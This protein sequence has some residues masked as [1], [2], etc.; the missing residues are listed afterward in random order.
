LNA[1]QYLNAYKAC[2]KDN[3]RKGKKGKEDIKKIE[4]LENY[5]DKKIKLLYLFEHPTRF[6]RLW[7]RTSRHPRLGVL[8]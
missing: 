6:M 2:L 4:A 8:L 7:S 1:E 5:L 3:Y